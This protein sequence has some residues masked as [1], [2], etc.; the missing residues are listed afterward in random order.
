MIAINTRTTDK[1]LAERLSNGFHF[2]LAMG[3]CVMTSDLALRI[4][5][6]LI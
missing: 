3:F 4:A 5:A 1:A 6:R 2:L